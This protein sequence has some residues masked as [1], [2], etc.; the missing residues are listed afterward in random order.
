MATLELNANAPCTWG[1]PSP[2]WFTVL[3]NDTSPSA[4]YDPAATPEN[5]EVRLRRA[6]PLEDRGQPTAA[7]SIQRVGVG[8]G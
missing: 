4:P 2:R 8:V 1:E 5:T 3:D 6:P 7:V